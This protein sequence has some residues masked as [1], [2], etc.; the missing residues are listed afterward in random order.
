MASNHSGKTIARSSHSNKLRCKTI[1]L[2]GLS[3]F[4]CFITSLGVDFC[5]FACSSPSSLGS[6]MDKLRLQCKIGI[7]IREH[8]YSAKQQHYFSDDIS[9]IQANHCEISLS[10]L[11][12]ILRCTYRLEVLSPFVQFTKIKQQYRTSSTTYES[13]LQNHVKEG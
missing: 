12:G 11:N 5:F 10:Y 8:K 9:K 4:Q 3:Q 2:L 7:S 1:T 13:T 6:I